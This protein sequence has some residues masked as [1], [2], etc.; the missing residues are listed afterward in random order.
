MNSDPVSGTVYEFKYIGGRPYDPDQMTGRGVFLK[1]ITV[2]GNDYYLV[3][4]KIDN[5]VHP[6]FFYVYYVSKGDIQKS[7]GAN[8]DEAFADL[9]KA[10]ESPEYQH[11]KYLKEFL[12]PWVLLTQDK[13]EELTGK[14][15][16]RQKI[17]N[18]MTQA[19]FSPPIRNKNDK[20]LF[21]GGPMYKRAFAN[22]SK[23]GGKTRRQ[24]K[25]RSKKTRKH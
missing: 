13:I 20:V 8:T 21:T 25:K 15:A 9:Q 10:I 3:G 5:R 17:K 22:F 11:P 23:K 24:H 14:K 19:I 18:F 4:Q 16:A 7:L 12:T 6:P 2:D 1:K